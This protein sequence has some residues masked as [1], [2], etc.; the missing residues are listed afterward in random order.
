M[1]AGS[2]AHRGGSGGA[3]GRSGQPQGQSNTGYCFTHACAVGTGFCWAED[4][5]GHALAGSFD[6]SSTEPPEEFLR[7]VSDEHATEGDPEPDDERLISQVCVM[8]NLWQH[9][10]QPASGP[11]D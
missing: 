6:A 2:D 3:D 11:R 4:H 5:G 9:R 1:N 8:E 10:H 7:S